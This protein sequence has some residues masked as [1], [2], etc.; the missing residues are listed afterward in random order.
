MKEKVQSNVF[1]C[2]DDWYFWRGSQ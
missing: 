1:Y 2:D